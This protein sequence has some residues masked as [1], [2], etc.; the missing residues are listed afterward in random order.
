MTDSDDRDERMEALEA[1]IRRREPSALAEYVNLRRP[2]LL[3]YIERNLSA[4]LAR[5]TEAE[6]LL[7]EATAAALRAL[8][9]YDMGDR[10]PFGWL[11]QMAER[12]IVDAHRRFASGKRDSGKEIPMS[13]GSGE[14]G[15][16]MED[17]L[18]ASMTSAS[19]A[20]SR[21]QRE[22]RLL[23]AIEQLDDVPKQA[24]RL[25]YAEN[26]PTKEIAERLG[27]TDGSVRV[28]LTRSLAKL[29]EIMG[30]DA[31]TF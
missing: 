13:A 16:G 25:R 31:P 17:L 6:D 1:G 9:E 4:Q 11:C 30:D 26:L 15:R 7:Q 10:D 24:I 27:K 19:A 18:V 20:F 5:K 23:A 29:R 3:A 14:D 8:P 2:Q 22:F 12:R 21:N 28:M